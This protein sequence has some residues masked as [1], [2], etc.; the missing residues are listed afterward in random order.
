MTNGLLGVCTKAEDETMNT[1]F[2]ARGKKRLNKVFDV[3]CF[4][5][6]DY[7]FSVRKQGP[8]KRIA[9]T[10]AY[11]VPKPKRVKVVTHRPKSYFLEK[12]VALPTS[13]KTEVVESSEATFSALEVI[14]VAAVEAATA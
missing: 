8:K 7:C 1:A 6:L 2:G 10:T 4:V 5:Y 14:P 9:S 3:I 13:E 12:D 11:T